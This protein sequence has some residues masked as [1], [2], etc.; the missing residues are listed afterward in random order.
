MIKSFFEGRKK[1]MEMEEDILVKE[2]KA[3]LF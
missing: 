2:K 1:E 3:S